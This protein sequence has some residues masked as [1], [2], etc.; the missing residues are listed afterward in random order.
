M[1]KK[2]LFAPFVCPQPLFANNKKMINQQKLITKTNKKGEG[3]QERKKVKQERNVGKRSG[4]KGHNKRRKGEER[5]EKNKKGRTVEKKK[6]GGCP[7]MFFMCFTI[8]VSVDVLKRFSFFS[9][10]ILFVCDYHT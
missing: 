5:K 8:L 10:I 7:R 9:P 1:G 4:R 6:N 2:P 3:K